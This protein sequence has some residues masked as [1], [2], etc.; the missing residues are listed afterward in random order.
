MF[1]LSCGG[2]YHSVI[3]QSCLHL[4]SNICLNPY[5]DMSFDLYWWIKNQSLN[6][7]VFLNYNTKG[8]KFEGKSKNIVSI[9]YIWNFTP[10]QNHRTNWSILHEILDLTIQC[11]ICY[12]WKKLQPHF[13]N[14]RE[15]L[16]F[17][18]S[19]SNKFGHINMKN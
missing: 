8:I 4:W 1:Q 6:L 7:K 18:I 5:G 19:L 15:F 13:W 17:G 12:Y 16:Q 10:F 9:Y 3:N 14:Y 11:V 2:I